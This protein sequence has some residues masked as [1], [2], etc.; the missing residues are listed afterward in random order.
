MVASNH[1]T[2]AHHPGLAPDASRR[3]ARFSNRDDPIDELDSPRSRFGRSNTLPP[4]A[5][6]G[7]DARDIQLAAFSE[8]CPAK[9][10]NLSFRTNG[11]LAALPPAVLEQLRPMLELIELPLGKVL[12]EPG[13]TSSHAYFPVTAIVSLQL[14]TKSGDC[15]ECAIVG[16]DGLVGVAL[17]MG[18]STMP[19][20]A[21]VQSPGTAYRLSADNMTAVFNEGGPLLRLFLRYTQ[22]LITQMSQTAVCNRHH[23]VQQQL[24]RLLLLCHDRLRGNEVVMTQ[25]LLA[26][27]MGVRR[28]SITS[29]ALKLQ[30]EGTIRYQRGHITIL[31]RA[32]L[33]AASCECYAV[34]KN[35]YDRLLPD[36]I[37]A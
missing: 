7:H 20:H 4:A 8:S 1:S 30:V 22:A 26:N 13:T 24:C 9:I 19:T 21:V 27:M 32:K 34:V 14:T 25:E 36:E 12:H 3:A 5:T 18:G 2:H 33:E 15:S 28:E 17:F 11:L 6:Q 31:D 29:A 10:F 37:A 16:N 23:G 35:E